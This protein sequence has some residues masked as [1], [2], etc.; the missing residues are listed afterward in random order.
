MS[1]TETT[2]KEQEMDSPYKF[3]PMES[4]IM[5]FLRMIYIMERASTSGISF[6]IF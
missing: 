6:S 3:I 2:L 4:I 5:D 1:I